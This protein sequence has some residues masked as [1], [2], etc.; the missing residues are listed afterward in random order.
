MTAEDS[1]TVRLRTIYVSSG[2]DESFFDDVKDQSGVPIING[3][4]LSQGTAAE[5]VEHPPSDGAPNE[6]N[7]H[8]SREGTV[9]PLLLPQSTHTLLFT[10]RFCSLP[11]FFASFIVL[12]SYTCLLL[13]QLDSLGGDLTFTEAE[14]WNIPTNVTREVRV[15]QYLSIF[16]A[17]M[18]EE[19]KFSSIVDWCFFMDIFSSSLTPKNNVIFYDNTN[20]LFHNKEIPT[21]LYMLRMIRRESFEQKL[22]DKNYKRFV[23]SAVVRIF[24]VNTEEEREFSPWLKIIQYPFLIIVFIVS[25]FLLSI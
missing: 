25:G 9:E 6:N 12:L 4:R 18:T 17:I 24:M 13:V 19:G 7:G 15:A 11:Y 22:P 10:E 20:L 8:N 3:G 23:F 5:D 16:I 14:D 2:D 21:G 1:D